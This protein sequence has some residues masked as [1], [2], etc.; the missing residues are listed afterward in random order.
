MVPTCV[1]LVL[2]KCL[3]AWW[4]PFFWNDVQPQL[5]MMIPNASDIHLPINEGKNTS[6]IES[7]PCW[8]VV[9]NMAVVFPLGMSSSQLTNSYF[10]EGLKPPIN[11][12]Y[13]SRTQCYQQLGSKGGGPSTTS[14]P[15]TWRVRRVDVPN[16][17]D[18]T[19]ISKNFRERFWK[20]CHRLLSADKTRFSRRCLHFQSA[21][22]SM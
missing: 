20:N 13:R 16:S 14:N 3:L 11:W 22:A 17:K 21:G 7:I 6:Q 19:W 18:P 9:W 10:S 4:F 2:A 1:C 15:K 12:V 5:G 8:L